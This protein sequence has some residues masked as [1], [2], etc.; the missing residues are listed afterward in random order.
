MYG[1]MGAHADDGWVGRGCCV[2]VLPFDETS[3]VELFRKIVKADFAYPSW[4][5]PEA[6][7]V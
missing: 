4:F 7:C 6:I 3:M 5:T 1:M 2:L